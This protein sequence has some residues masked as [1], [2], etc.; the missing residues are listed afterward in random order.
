MAFTNPPTAVAASRG[1]SQGAWNTYIKGNLTFI[2]D[3]TVATS[4]VHGLPSGVYPIGCENGVGLFIQTAQLTNCELPANAGR[5]YY[6]YSWT[7]P[8]AFTATPKCFVEA[9][10]A[11]FAISNPQIP[12]IVKHIT[13]LSATGASIG[14]NHEDHYHAD[15]Y[16]CAIG[17]ITIAAKTVYA[18]HTPR[19]WTDDEKIPYS[20]W[21]DEVRDDVCYIKQRH[22]DMPHLV[23]GIGSGAYPAGCATDGYQMD[24]Q[25]VSGTTKTFTR[26]FSAKPAVVVRVDAAISYPGTTTVGVTTASDEILAIGPE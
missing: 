26:A 10:V 13:A 25:S 24:C 7:F 22:V 15:V 4:A 5:K 14:F 8:V 18:W 1:I 20:W 6:T 12:N 19:T 17:P 11:S 3:H 16:A 21:N 9:V 2:Y 23:H